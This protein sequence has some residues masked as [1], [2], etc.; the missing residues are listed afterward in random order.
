MLNQ[1][2][3]PQMT[4]PALGTGPPGS[5]L[6]LQELSLPPAGTL[7]KPSM[8]AAPPSP[9]RPVSG[10]DSYLVSPLPPGSTPDRLSLSWAG[11]PFQKS[12]SDL[13][14][15][16]SIPSSIIT[17]PFYLK[18]TKNLTKA[19]KPCPICTP[20]LPGPPWVLQPYWL[21]PSSTVR[22]PR[23]P[24][25]QG[26]IFLLST[27]LPQSTVPCS[28]SSAVPS[29]LEGLLPQEVACSHPHPLPMVSS[30]CSL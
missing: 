17:P 21:T 11:W 4:P 19:Y 26:I 13:V 22:G 18:T 28:C 25:A 29:P 8:P 6:H 16:S 2:G 3:V 15:A 30:H 9:G 5:A 10:L 7:R 1:P 23:R 27:P 24:K 20:C 14:T 12:R